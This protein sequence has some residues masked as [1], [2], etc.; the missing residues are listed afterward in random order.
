MFSQ[1]HKRT[2]ISWILNTKLF[3]HFWAE[4][5]T[6]RRVWKRNKYACSSCLND[7]LGRFKLVGFGRSWS[8]LVG[9]GRFWSV[10][11]P[12][13][14]RSKTIKTDPFGS[15]S[16]LNERLSCRKLFMELA[17]NKLVIIVFENYV[18]ILFQLMMNKS[19]TLS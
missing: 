15:S 6:M 5:I 19:R 10:L 11:L 16:C 13:L 9:F 2:F 14:K 7:P 12:R 8:V 1:S 18:T 3:R 17:Y 4:I